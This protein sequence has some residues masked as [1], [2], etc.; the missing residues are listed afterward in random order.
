[1]VF[2]KKKNPP[3]YISKGIARCIVR[4]QTSVLI[5]SHR[6]NDSYATV[7]LFWTI[8]NISWHACSWSIFNCLFCQCIC[9]F[10]YGMSNVKIFDSFLLYDYFH[11][12]SKINGL[13]FVLKKKLSSMVQFYS[14]FVCIVFHLYCIISYFIA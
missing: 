2:G 8:A 12:W 3:L 10:K 14:A 11:F 6:N 13:S 5:L 9:A 7:L 1:M 4:V